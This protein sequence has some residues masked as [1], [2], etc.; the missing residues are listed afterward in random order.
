[1]SLNLKRKRYKFEKYTFKNM[2]NYYVIEG[3]GQENFYTT[4]EK[5]ETVYKDFISLGKKLYLRIENINYFSNV[6]IKKREML[7]INLISLK[8]ENFIYDFNNSDFNYLD[9][10]EPDTNHV[11]YI[12]E[13]DK[14]I[15]DTFLI[16]IIID[17]CKDNDLPYYENIDQDLIIE[18]SNNNLP[19]AIRAKDLIFT[20]I[21]IFLLSEI[22]KIL[23]TKLTKNDKI[24][25]NQIMRFNRIEE[26]T[27]YRDEFKHYI[28][29][30]E[31]EYRLF[32]STYKNYTTCITSNLKENYIET[33]NLVQ[34]L[35]YY[36]LNCVYLN[37]TTFN[38]C[39]R[40]SAPSVK[41]TQ[42]LCD[43][44]F[45]EAPNF[46]KNNTRNEL[47]N[48]CKILVN[49]L[50]VLEKVDIE[51]LINNT[52]AVKSN[53]KDSSKKDEKLLLELCEKYQ[54]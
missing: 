21:T 19:L 27:V 2:F 31:Q 51:E 24:H 15:N 47:N 36:F 17:F 23:D 18:S 50:R 53:F 7:R 8:G 5:L 35:T 13:Y 39:H 11:I 12:K 33:N 28:N 30:L 26:D 49:K 25:L 40:C 37:N 16:N 6:F 46:D 4:V 32:I 43:D 44:C 9:D 52:S 38:L 54:I 20:S 29:N 34:A 45:K 14:L 1:M 48:R 10:L 42:N 41:L 3:S 22:K